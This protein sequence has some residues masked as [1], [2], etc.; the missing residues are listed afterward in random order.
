M[1][2]PATRIKCYITL[3]PF[4]FIIS[5]FLQYLSYQLQIACALARDHYFGTPCQHFKVWN[6]WRPFEKCAAFQNLLGWNHWMTLTRRQ[7]NLWQGK[8]ADKRET[9]ALESISA[10][11]SMKPLDIF[12]LVNFH[13]MFVAQEPGKPKYDLFSK[14]WPSVSCALTLP[15]FLRE[16]K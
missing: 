5:T 16:S 14:P 8:V 11:V 10:L 6:R 7:D 2:F 15:V 4:I 12:T 13:G 3:V 9:T 1:F